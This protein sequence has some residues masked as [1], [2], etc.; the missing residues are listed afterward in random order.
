MY[1]NRPCIRQVKIEILNAP[2]TWCRIF[3]V[4]LARGAQMIL[5][6]NCKTKLKSTQ[7]C[8]DLNFTI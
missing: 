7:Y 5:F 4:Q 2:G 1:H 8:P 6:D 3:V